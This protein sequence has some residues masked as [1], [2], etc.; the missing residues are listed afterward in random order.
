MARWRTASGLRAGMPRPWRVK[1]FAQRRPGGAELGRGGI[2]AAELL[3]Q[4]EST[5]G[6]GAVGQEPAGLPAHPP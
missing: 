3:G 1:V 4:L 6:L 5:F 2:D